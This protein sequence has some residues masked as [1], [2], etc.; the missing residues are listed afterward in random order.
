MSKT[1]LH[2]QPGDRV[3]VD[4]HP[5]TVFSYNADA[6]R[7]ADYLYLVKLDAG[8]KIDAAVGPVRT[9]W[10]RPADLSAVT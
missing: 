9:E 4:G 6:A 10:F 8:H 7:R 1:T 3:N 5:G 2:Y